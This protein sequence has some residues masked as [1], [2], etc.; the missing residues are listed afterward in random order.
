MVIIPKNQ[1]NG[2]ATIALAKTSTVMNEFINDR[3]IIKVD[4]E[5][6][7]RIIKNKKKD[8]RSLVFVSIIVVYNCT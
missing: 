1:H 4:N 3:N 7:K 8:I 5:L 6:N 2:I